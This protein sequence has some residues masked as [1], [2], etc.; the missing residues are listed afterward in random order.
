MKT[1]MNASNAIHV[2]CLALLLGFAST[3]AIA[4]SDE[5]F[6]KKA[7]QG[8]L[9]EVKM[10][11]LAQQRAQSPEVKEF[12]QHLVNEHQQANAELQE[13]AK[14]EGIELK[15]ELS[16]KHKQTVDRLEKA[17]GQAFDKKF[18]EAVVKEHKKDIKEF[19]KQAQNGKDP[20]VKDWAQ[21][22]LPA[23][24]KHLQ[25]AQ[26]V[27]QQVSQG[28]KGASDSGGSSADDSGKDKSD[29]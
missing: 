12:A 15:D 2:G 29:Q 3:G 5:S 18:M 1:S 14:A 4:A 22:T 27:Q 6:V 11:E 23:L 26:Q 20:D 16:G 10:G 19:K 9:T 25:M 17:N 24:E 28:G 7:N 21:K 8:G 13:L